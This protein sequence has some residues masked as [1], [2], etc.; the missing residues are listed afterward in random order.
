MK[1]IIL[2]GAAG[3]LLLV[4]WATTGAW[5]HSTGHESRT[6]ADCEKLPTPERQNCIK[7]VTRPVKHHFHPDYP[8]GERCRPDNGKP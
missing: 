7:C 1:K 6:I 8:P 4:G 2:Y 5:A 3:A